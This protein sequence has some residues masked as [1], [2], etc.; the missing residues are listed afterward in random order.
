LIL[1]LE[2]DLLIWV[3]DLGSGWHRGDLRNT[4][5][6]S[7]KNSREKISHHLPKRS[8]HIYVIVLSESSPSHQKK[9]TEPK[10][11]FKNNFQLGSKTADF[12][13]N[14][15]QKTLRAQNPFCQKCQF[16]VPLLY[17]RSKNKKSDR[18]KK[19]KPLDNQGV[20]V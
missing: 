3:N 12:G 5:W 14:R 2:F 11:F 20:S 16:V 15:P 9:I 8:L 6:P 18:P 13:F 7:R 19:E 1:V 4:G 10:N 17:L